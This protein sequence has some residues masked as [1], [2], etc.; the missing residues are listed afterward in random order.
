MS[1]SELSAAPLFRSMYAPAFP[2]QSFAPELP[3]TYHDGG[4]VV[5]DGKPDYLCKQTL[6]NTFIEH[7]FGRLNRH[8]SQDSSHAALQ[9]EYGHHRPQSHS[10]LS[11]HFWTNGYRSGQVLCL[12]HGHNH[13]LY[14]VLALQAEHGWWQYIVVF[15]ANPT[16]ADAKAYCEAGLVWCTEA[17][18][19]RLLASIDLCAHGVYFPF[20]FH[21][22]KYSVHVQPG[23]KLSP[24]ARRAVFEAVIATETASRHASEAAAAADFAAGILPF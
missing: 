5:R 21:T 13:S 7:K 12:E 4:N 3:T 17:S 24:D 19:E 8:L 22:T 20:A 14:K 9:A 2:R 10:F 15:K 6:T 23:P 16:P 1:S 18:V 11:N